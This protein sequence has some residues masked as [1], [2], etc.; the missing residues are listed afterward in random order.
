MVSDIPAGDGKLVNLF[1]RCRRAYLYSGWEVPGAVESKR[2]IQPT[3]WHIRMILRGRER[4]YLN[5]CTKVFI[6]SDTRA[7]KSAA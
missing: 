4:M 1:L 5:V 3:K 6:S 2:H 7:G